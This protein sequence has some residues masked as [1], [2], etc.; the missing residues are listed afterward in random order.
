MGAARRATLSWG[1]AL[2][3]AAVMIAGCAGSEE[4]ARSDISPTV[5]TRTSGAG[6][7]PA[8]G[9]ADQHALHNLHEVTDGVYSGGVP[10]G[11]AAFAE[12]AALGV[13]AVIS[14]DGAAPDVERAE[15]HGM[16]Y[17]HV[18]VTYSE[19]APEQQLE[20]ARAMRDL[21]G[22]VY[23]HCHHGKH[24]G[25]AAAA[26]A[27]IALGELTPQEGVAFLK[28][29]GT[30]PQYEGLYA[31][32][33][34]ATEASIEEIDRASSEFPSI[35][36]PSGL[37]AAMVEVDF[38]FENLKEIQG[39]GWRT[40]ADHPDL[41][42]AAEARRLA[43]QLRFGG[44]DAKCAELG[45]DFLARLRKAIDE[46]TALEA[47]IVSREEASVIEQSFAAVGASCKSCHAAY[48]D[49]R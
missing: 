2:V 11:D 23:L 21:P 30:S 48:R 28:L 22:P 8:H 18:P 13:K 33:G 46:A 42:P 4:R 27:A 43:D 49:R 15:A 14:V 34:S 47:A 17:V 24:R 20:I 25:P 45:P 19:I 36:R 38:A 41:V 9:A 6:A 40:P 12:M 35:R 29:A 39:A 10:E 1:G 31:C 32:V 16:R 37:V 26:S 3:A 44:E 5:T 7:A